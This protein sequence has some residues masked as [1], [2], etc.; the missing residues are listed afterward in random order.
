MIES[1]RRIS[2]ELLLTMQRTNNYNV[3]SLWENEDLER[4]K[5]KI[6][7]IKNNKKK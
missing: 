5:M 1:I 4:E 7:E 3:N 6:V 2:R